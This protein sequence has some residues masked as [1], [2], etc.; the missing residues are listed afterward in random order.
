MKH[1]KG[2]TRLT[3][4]VWG[5]HFALLP[6][7]AQR[8]LDIEH[9]P[10][11]LQLIREEL[12]S[13]YLAGDP[14][15]AFESGEEWRIIHRCLTGG[16]L[17]YASGP[18]PLSYAMLGGEML[19]AGRKATACF[20]NPSQVRELAAALPQVSWKQ[21]FREYGGLVNT[22][23]MQ[24]D[25]QLSRAEFERAWTC[26]EGLR[27]FFDAAATAERPVLFTADT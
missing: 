13:I 8:V 21:L 4:D 17:R 14:V 18:F 7:H 3:G 19:D 23:Y 27:T 11:L 26:F 5:V 25:Q 2:T 24:G 16:E 1:S 15:W 6:D 12:P 10:D 22:S 9:S 20:V